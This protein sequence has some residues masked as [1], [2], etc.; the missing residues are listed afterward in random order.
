MAF[1]DDLE[2]SLEITSSN[3]PRFI[4][5]DFNARIG[6]RRPNEDDV[7]GE[8]CFGREAVHKV[9]VPNRDLLMEFCLSRSRVVGNTFLPNAD[10]QKVTYFEP[11]ARP[12]EDI[13]PSKFAMLD[14]VLLPAS[15]SH[16]LI[17]GY[18]D[19]SCSI[20]SH[21]FPFT[22]VLDVQLHAAKKKI[23]KQSVDWSCLREPYFREQ[24]SIEFKKGLDGRLRDQ[25]AAEWSNLRECVAAT[26]RKTLPSVETRKSN[27][28]ISKGTLKL[29]DEKQLA[30]STGEYA[31][32]L[33]L[34]KEV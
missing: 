11:W 20:A 8:Y 28:W 10:D 4:F 18:S 17:T 5:G 19:R 21:H 31:E 32:E 22:S 34:R 24:F 33:R 23:R 27:P 9:E 6:Q 1:Y 15:C 3:G 14:L 29:I 12:L 2:R 25:G 30:R 13:T 26:A 16:R 7:L